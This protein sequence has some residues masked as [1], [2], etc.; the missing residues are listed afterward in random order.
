LFVLLELA[1]APG[2]EGCEA[3]D[4]GFGSGDFAG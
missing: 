3:I 1:V 2:A 4:F